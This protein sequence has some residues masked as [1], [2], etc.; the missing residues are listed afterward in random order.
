M[1]SAS[2]SPQDLATLI[3]VSQDLGPP[4]VGVVVS[5]LLFGVSI[6]QT[7]IYY[8]KTSNDMLVFRVS[9]AILW[10]LD[11]FGLALTIHAIYHYLITNFGN[12]SALTILVWSLKMKAAVDLVIVLLVQS[13]Y[14][15]RLW[16]LNQGKAWALRLLALSIVGGIGISIVF[17]V[18]IYKMHLFSDAVKIQWAFT[19]TF[20]TV[21]TIDIAIAGSICYCLYRSR[22]EFAATNSIISML[23]LWTLSTGLVTIICSLAALITNLTMPRSFVFLSFNFMLSKLYFNSL[24]AMLNS[25]GEL[26]ERLYSLDTSNPLNPSPKCTDKKPTLPVSSKDMVNTGEHMFSFVLRAGISL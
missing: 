11:A 6:L 5:A 19:A 26:K 12:Y 2:V 25:R 9:V 10:V 22:P 20:S 23:M 16:K 4:F 3:N 21:I 8:Q 14:C 13:L 17:V 18:E 7:Y 15:L 24:L 1:T